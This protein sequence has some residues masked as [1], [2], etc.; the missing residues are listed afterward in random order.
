MHDGLAE[1]GFLVNL[2]DILRMIGDPHR[3]CRRERA[4]DHGA[5]QRIPLGT[6]PHGFS[7]AAR[8]LGLANLVGR[9]IQTALSTIANALAHDGATLE[10]SAARRARMRPLSFCSR[11]MAWPQKAFKG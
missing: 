10:D 6:S 3:P 4:F 5:A 9:P 11:S 2:E 1:Q 8:A 7:E